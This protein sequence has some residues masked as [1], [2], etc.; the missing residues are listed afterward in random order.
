MAW[1]IPLEVSALRKVRQPLR[2]AS[3]SYAATQV[4]AF[5]AFWGART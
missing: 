4:V 1:V 3:S 5:L 2:S